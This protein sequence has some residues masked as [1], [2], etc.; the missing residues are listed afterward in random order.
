MGTGS[1]QVAGSIAVVDTNVVVYY[2]LG[3]DH[4]HEEAANAFS[5][6]LQLLAPASMRAELLSAIWQAE[7]KGVCSLED[8]I[9]LL[10]LTN[11]LLSVMVPVEALWRE[12]L[13]AAV[14][15]G[16]SPY[17]TL[18]VVLAEREGCFLLSFDEELLRKF[19]LIVRCPG[20]HGLRR[21]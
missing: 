9:G 10:E 11:S 2:L 14:E 21:D 8:G 16:V 4:Q 5:H 18:F 15:A 12:A 13:V 3:T 20:R 7:R 6:G 17:D 19:P 1:S